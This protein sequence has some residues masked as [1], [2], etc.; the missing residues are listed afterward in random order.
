VRDI[1]ASIASVSQA[2]DGA[3]AAMAEAAEAAEEARFTSSEVWYAAGN[4]GQEAET[5]GREFDH[6][7]LSMRDETSE[8]RAF[9]R[10]PCN[11]APVVL[12]LPDDGTAQ[13]VLIDISRG[14]LAM[15]AVATDMVAT[16][17]SGTAIKVT[18]PDGLGDVALRVVRVEAGQIGFVACQTTETCEIMDK[19]VGYFATIRKAA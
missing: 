4:V 14:G 6:F 3:V 17:A 5:L 13:G 11:D 7:L 1:V 18:L 19:A 15:K 16:L 2:T 8:K 12:H 10:V 9:Q